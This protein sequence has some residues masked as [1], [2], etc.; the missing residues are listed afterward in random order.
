MKITLILT[1]ILLIS[2]NKI[3]DTDN[4][5]ITNNVKSIESSDFNNNFEIIAN[6]TDAS[7]NYSNVNILKII[8]TKIKLRNLKIKTLDDL[9]SA[10]ELSYLTIKDKKLYID[11]LCKFINDN[12]IEFGAKI[13]YY[14]IREKLF[15][16]GSDGDKL[17]LAISAME[18][19]ISHPSDFNEA[20]NVLT[21]VEYYVMLSEDNN[22]KSILANYFATFYSIQDDYENAKAWY[23]KRI[24]F[25]DSIKE[26][27]DITYIITEIEKKSIPFQEYETNMFAFFGD[28]N[29][30]FESF[31][32]ALRS[33]SRAKAMDNFSQNK[34]LKINY[35]IEEEKEKIYEELKQKYINKMD[36][37]L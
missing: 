10:E 17:F 6:K 16:I 14:A 25:V 5:F 9:F 19:L 13:Y 31:D 37:N 1:I 32:N 27:Q 2:C 33:Y 28:A 4:I 36:Y 21:N 11:I 26:K 34:I 15:D 30:E 35:T 3:I 23:M 22:L 8:E 20:Y 29:P 24:N 12:S 7:L 18:S